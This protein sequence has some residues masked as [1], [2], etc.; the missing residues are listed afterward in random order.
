M[1]RLCTPWPL[2]L[3]EP[4]FFPLREGRRPCLLGG[5]VVTAAGWP[6]VPQPPACPTPR[7]LLVPPGAVGRTRPAPLTAQAFHPGHRETLGREGLCPARRTW[8]PACP[9]SR[10]AAGEQGHFPPALLGH[11][12]VQRE[13]GAGPGDRVR[14]VDAG[15]GSGLLRGHRP[16]RHRRACRPAGPFT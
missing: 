10:W 16:H 7:A 2:N 13:A 14:G 15:G 3:L 1:V 8:G 11:V 6:L 12:E 9:A 5:G 4:L